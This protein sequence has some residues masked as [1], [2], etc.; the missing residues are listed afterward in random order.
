MSGPHCVQVQGPSPRHPQMSSS[1]GIG[2]VVQPPRYAS[3]ENAAPAPPANAWGKPKATASTVIGPP[4]G[5]SP[6][7]SLLSSALGGGSSSM[8]ASLPDAV[9]E[10]CQKSRATS[11]DDS[12][13]C[14]ERQNWWCNTVNMIVLLYGSLHCYHKMART[15][16]A[17]PWKVS[18]RLQRCPRSC[19][20][21][22]P[23]CASVIQYLIS[24]SPGDIVGAAQLRAGQQ[25]HPSEGLEGP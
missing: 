4:S 3:A 2:P 6:G 19:S 11:I 5:Q 7:T 13:S 1:L 16:R 24:R 21:S 9:C 25:L 8:G 20:Y 18:C 15:A 23:C 12:S 14:I 17:E 10:P 22:A